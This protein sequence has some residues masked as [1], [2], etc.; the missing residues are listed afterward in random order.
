M[1]S[2]FEKGHEGYSDFVTNIYKYRSTH[3]SMVE[4][5]RDNTPTSVS[6]PQSYIQPPPPQTAPLSSD[7]LCLEP[8]LFISLA[9]E[10]CVFFHLSVY[11][12]P[13]LFLL[14]PPLKRWG[15]PFLHSLEGYDVLHSVTTKSSVNSFSFVFFLMV[16]QNAQG[17]RASSSNPLLSLL[18]HSMAFKN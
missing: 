4:K 16:K 12:H 18:Q 10:L 9:S 2:L 8:Q 1:A 6:F 11:T 7:S 5:V 17:R 13:P 3:Y 14:L 15:V